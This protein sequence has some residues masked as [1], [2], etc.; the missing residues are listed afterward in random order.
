MIIL[1]ELQIQEYLTPNIA[2]G[3]N[4]H[5]FYLHAHQGDVTPTRLAVV[6]P[7]TTNSTSNSH[8]FGSNS[9]GGVTLFK[10]SLTSNALGLKIVSVR[11]D[12]VKYN[13]QTVPATIAMIDRECGDMT[14]LLAATTLTA[15]RTAA[16]SAVATALFASKSAHT[17]SVIGGGLQGREHIRAILVIRKISTVHIFNRNKSRAEELCK[18]LQ[19]LYSHVNFNAFKIPSLNDDHSSEAIKALQN[20]QIICTCTGSSVPV[21][22][23]HMISA[24]THINAVGSYQPHTRECTTDV[25]ARASIVVDDETAKGSGDIAIAIKENPKIEQQ[26]CGSLGEY[27]PS[28]FANYVQG[29]LEVDASIFESLPKQLPIT[30]EI[31][32]FKS[33]GIAVQD[34]VTGAVAVDIAKQKKVGTLIDMDG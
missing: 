33:V 20:S 7:P 28:T 19:Q 24:G 4:A 21:L 34:I 2:I 8:E 12:N 30:S 11:S 32:F 3:A 6:I 22:S 14:A 27:V 16:G 18:S 13:K 9:A 5:A 15:I 23:S 31:T 17:L 25:M 1:T 26:L 29:N 10:P